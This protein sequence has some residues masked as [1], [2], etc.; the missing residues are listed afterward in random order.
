MQPLSSADAAQSIFVDYECLM[1]KPPHPALLGVLIGSGGEDLQQFIVDPELAPARV[2]KRERTSVAEV[3]DVVRNIVGM[4]AACDLRIVGWSYFDRDRMIEACPDLGHVIKARYVNALHI[5]RPWRRTIY[6]SFKIEREDEHSPKHTLDQYA[7]LAD[8]SHGFAFEDAEPAKWIRH[9]RKQLRATG[10]NYRRTTS[11][12]KRDWHKLL[13]YN[14]HDLLALRGIVLKATRELE[15]WHA[16]ERT[17]FCADDG[18]R[19]VCFMAGSRSPRLQALLRRHG[20]TRWAFMTAWNSAWASQHLNGNAMRQ[21]ELIK[22]VEA[23]GYQMLPGEAI[24]EDPVSTPAEGVLILGMGRREAVPLGERFEQLAIL[25]GEDDG[26]A[27][28]VSC[29]GPG[30]D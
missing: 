13:D 8:Y 6:P 11:Q 24:G 3:D 18:P 26:P 10:G 20:V 29:G 1:G 14:R 16:Y 7:V 9:V 19:R 2:A 12:T 27:T 5:A 21:V 4:A 23:R 15:L 22:I 25:V 30:M 17:R 28:L